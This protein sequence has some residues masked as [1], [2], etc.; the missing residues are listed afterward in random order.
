MRNR[1]AIYTYPYRTLRLSSNLSVLH[2]RS[3]YMRANGGSSA[4]QIQN[5]RKKKKTKEENVALPA[6]HVIHWRKN[7]D[8]FL[9]GLGNVRVRVSARWNWQ[10]TRQPSASMVTHKYLKCSLFAI[11]CFSRTLTARNMEKPFYLFIFFSI[12]LFVICQARMLHRKA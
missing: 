8:T 4:S 1:H 7:G 2:R 10:C 6:S 3:S 12:F 9:I 11:S 5:D